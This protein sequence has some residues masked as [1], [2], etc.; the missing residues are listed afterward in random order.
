[1]R[2]NFAMIAQRYTKKGAIKMFET[3]AVLFIFLVLL[4]LAMVF[5]QTIQKSSFEDELARRAEMKSLDISEKALLLPEID[6]G[7]TERNCFDMLKV[8]SFSTVINK[9]DDARAEFFNVFENSEITVRQIWPPADWSIVMYNRTPETFRSLTQ[10][11]SPIV[12][13]HPLTNTKTFGYLEVK[14]YAQ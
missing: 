14:T 7:L 12:L 13:Y 10:Y 2:I 6:C 8:T 5:Y 9:N 1:M 3:I 4:A 11:A